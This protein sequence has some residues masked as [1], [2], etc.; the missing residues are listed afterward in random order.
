MSAGAQ[1]AASKRPLVTIASCAGSVGPDPLVAGVEKDRSYRA[2]LPCGFRAV[3]IA[4]G[5]V[6]GGAVRFN[7]HLK[8]AG[9]NFTVCGQVCLAVKFNNDATVERNT[10]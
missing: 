9:G 10:S 7:N 2:G 5:V 1:G 6:G 8:T 3:R 4:G